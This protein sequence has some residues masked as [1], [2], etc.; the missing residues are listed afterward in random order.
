MPL[1]SLRTLPLVVLL[2][3]LGACGG[4]SDTEPMT[5]GLDRDAV[6][7][8]P[9]AGLSV[10]DPPAPDAG[11]APSGA[12][13]MPPAAGP[14]DAGSSQ[15]TVDAGPP[16]P[17]GELLPFLPVADASEGLTNTGADLGA[18]L[19][20]GALASACDEWRAAPGDRRKKLL[21]G[22]AMFFYEGFGTT[23][24]P[25]PLITW[26][27]TH[28]PTEVG[29]GF[30]LLGMVA[31]PNSTEN[32][33][34]GL[35]RGAP[36]GSTETLAFTCASCHLGRLP[37][38][39]YAVGAPNHDYD[40]GRM[41]LL[42]TLLPQ[43]QMPGWSDA[44]HDTHA[45]A[46]LEPLRT[47]LANDLGKRL[48]LFAGLAPLALSGSAAPPFSRENEGYYA[49]WRPGTMDFF[50]QPLPFDD[51]VHTVSKI[52]ALWG[53][54][55]DAELSAQGIPSALLGWTGGTATVAHFLHSFV[56]LGGG[57]P[58]LW[59]SSALEPL[60]AYLATLRAPTA[61]AP[62]PADLTAGQ[63]SF[64]VNC[65]G[66]HEGPR[67]M[68]RRVYTFMEIGTDAAMQWWADGPDHDGAP[69]APIVFPAGDRITHGIKSPRLVGLG[70]MK[71]FLH[72]GSL[73]TLEQLLCLQQRPTVTT[74]ALGGGGHTFGCQLP[75][76]EREALLRYLRAH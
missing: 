41:N 9:D 35:A 76:P 3:A 30:S 28:F 51:Q 27:L 58:A 54:P 24:V 64:R 25:K 69:L 43:T 32:L 49:Q 1:V 55:S 38:G 40:Y 37:D 18:V 66:C 2:L 33:P 48:A 23:G 63:D 11:A 39:R 47:L 74:P 16:R 42:I 46:K 44:A 36:L 65:L 34:L 29:P 12:L 53:I 62:S 17:M 61:P 52:S 20:Q 72:N 68:G 4:Q 6:P 10:V 73:D 75:Q 56:E 8:L 26:L 67:G 5:P 19:E 21:C 59:P 31:D 45:L 14:G 71:R 22:K 60:E 50:I 57:D 13:V 15:A 7:P 70:S